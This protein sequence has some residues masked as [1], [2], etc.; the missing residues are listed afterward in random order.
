MSFQTI[1]KYAN[2][3]DWSQA[4]LPNLETENYPALKNDIAVI[5]EWMAAGRKVPRKQRR[6][7]LRLC[8]LGG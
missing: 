5:D 2:Q 4:K 1:Q 8:G 6:P 7:S 3:E